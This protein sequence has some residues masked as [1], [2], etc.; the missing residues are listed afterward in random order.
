[1]FTGPSFFV[2]AQVLSEKEPSVKRESQKEYYIVYEE[3]IMI[4]LFLVH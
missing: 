1:M 4:F 3:S 2:A